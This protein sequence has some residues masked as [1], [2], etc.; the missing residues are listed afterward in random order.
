MPRVTK[1]M[2][3]LTQWPKKQSE[4]VRFFVNLALKIRCRIVK[5]ILLTDY[6]FGDFAHWEVKL[7]NIF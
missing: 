3:P 4:V 7:N 5:S 6:F 1:S 2:Y